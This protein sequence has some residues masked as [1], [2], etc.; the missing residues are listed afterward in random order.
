[1]DIE[2]QNQIDGRR[3]YSQVKL[4]T[5]TINYDDVTTIV[6]KFKGLI[7]FARTNGIDV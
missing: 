6:N 1:M 3:K 2:F 4:W 5:N 7:W